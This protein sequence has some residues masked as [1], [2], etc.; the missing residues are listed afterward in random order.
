MLLEYNNVSRVDIQD[1]DCFKYYLSYPYCCNAPIPQCIQLVRIKTQNNNELENLSRG[2][3]CELIL[4][5]YLFT[6]NRQSSS[7]K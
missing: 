2:S 4:S 6:L 3:N 7:L 1:P 5:F